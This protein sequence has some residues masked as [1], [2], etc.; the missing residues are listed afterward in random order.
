MRSLQDTRYRK[1]I[2]RLKKARIAKDLTQVDVAKKIDRPQ[3]FVSKVE[4]LERRLDVIE[5]Y[6]LMRIYEVEWGEVTKAL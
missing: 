5:L 2:D 6:D 3:S 1:L 4:N